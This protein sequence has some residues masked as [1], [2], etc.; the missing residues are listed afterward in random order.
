MTYRRLIRVARRAEAAAGREELRRP[1]H[2]RFGLQEVGVER[3]DHAG[4][5]EVRATVFTGWP[6]AIRAPSRAFDSFTGA[7]VWTRACGS[8]AVS[9]SRRRTNV[10]EFVGCARMRS[11][12]PPSAANDATFPFS[13]DSNSSHFAG[14]ARA[15]AGRSSDPGRK[16]RG[17]RRLALIAFGAAEARRVLRVPLDLG[18]P[19]L[20]VLHHDADRVPAMRAHGRVVNGDPRVATCTRGPSRRGGCSP[21]AGARTLRRRGAPR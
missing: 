2:P 14:A 17:C 9:M 7:Q 19:P 3:Q 20:V 16:D 10:G 8:C 5:L 15:S 1:N 4:R 11:L 12:A 21:P 6:N 18:R 13:A